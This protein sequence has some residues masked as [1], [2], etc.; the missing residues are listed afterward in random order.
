M[1]GEG[2]MWCDGGGRHWW[3]L[4]CHPKINDECHSSFG[5]IFIPGQSL[6]SVGTSFPYAGSRF[7]T[8]AVVFIHGWLSHGGGSGWG[9]LMCHRQSFVV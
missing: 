6:S 3:V 8:W 2:V 7:Q 1:R 9:G 4:T 5:F